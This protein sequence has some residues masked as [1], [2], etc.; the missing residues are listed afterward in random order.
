MEIIDCLCG[1]GPWQKRD[2][3][4]PWQAADIAALLD[5]FGIA[6]A[7]VHSNFTDG[8]GSCVR[9]NEHVA[10]SCAEHPRFAP[11]FTVQPFWHDDGPSIEEQFAGLAAAGGRS[12]W[13]TPSPGSATRLIF[14]ETLGFC[15][16]ARLPVFVARERINP[17][18]I[19]EFLREFPRLRMVLAGCGYMDD[20]WLYPLLKR[21][22]GLFVC[23]GHYYIPAD[24][25]MRFLRHFPADRLLF[26]SGLPH[27]S[28]GGMIAHF[29]YADV[30]EEDRAKMLGGNASRLLEEVRI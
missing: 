24:G 3:L 20:W 9:G 23:S 18:E 28:P 13:L 25:P 12:L 5:H 2:P 16:R 29:T 17:S 26:G 10:K 6:R 30:S 1:V 8:G 14:G 4:L 19:D 27:F 15:E 7:L 22:P 11:M 21:H